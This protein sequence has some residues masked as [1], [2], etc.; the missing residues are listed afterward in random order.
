MT[1]E[2]FLS[3]VPTYVSNVVSDG[4]ITSIDGRLN[5]QPFHATWPAGVYVTRDEQSY[6]L[7][8]NFP[9][10]SIA[11]YERRRGNQGPAFAINYSKREPEERDGER[12]KVIHVHLHC[13]NP[14]GRYSFDTDAEINNKDLE[15]LKAI[16]D[17]LKPTIDMWHN[18]GNVNSIKLMNS[19]GRGTL[20]S[21]VVPQS[22]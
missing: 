18:I 2:D 22:E 6:Y 5:G 4:M 8:L 11:F 1:S 14:E 16:A 9:Q 7:R 20:D 3:K 12:R 15:R 10:Q 19:R 17:Y 13:N 21:L